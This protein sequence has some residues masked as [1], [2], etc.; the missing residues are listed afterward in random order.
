LKFPL[1][2]LILIQVDENAEGIA[3]AVKIGEF[4]V[5]IGALTEERVAEVLKAQSEGDA[6]RFGEIA[7]ARGFLEGSA[8]GRFTDFL[9]EHQDFPA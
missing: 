4:L 9:A 5:K 8:L 1:P 3:M 6:R 2:E 7:V